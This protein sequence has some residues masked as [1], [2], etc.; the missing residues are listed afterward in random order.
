MGEKRART[1]E[2]GALQ[3]RRRFM[4]QYMTSDGGPTHAEK[5]RAFD[6][7]TQMAAGLSACVTSSPVFATCAEDEA[8]IVA[9][10]DVL[11]GV[12]R[13][14]MD[15][16]CT[17]GA[18]RRHLQKAENCFSGLGMSEAAA[19][20]AEEY[21]TEDISSIVEAS[22][23]FFVFATAL[24]DRVGEIVRGTSSLALVSPR[25]PEKTSASFGAMYLAVQNALRVL[26][27]E[28]HLDEFIEVLWD[29]SEDEAGEEEGGIIVT[30]DEEEESDIDEESDLD[31]EDSE[32]GDSEDSV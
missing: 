30:T 19:R 28:L 13:L 11:W 26:S 17:D 25:P 9:V 20:L 15:F 16:A 23:A 24:G 12:V 32:D 4:Q 5:R 29:T 27:R 14:L 6:A 10:Q 7:A 8:G 2:E 21:I 22:P 31:E 18:S 1:G 3:I